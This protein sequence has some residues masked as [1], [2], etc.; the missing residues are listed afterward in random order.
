MARSTVPTYRA[1]VSRVKKDL[2]GERFGRLTVVSRGPDQVSAGGK[3]RACWNCVCD[4]GKH[5]L[6]A[7]FCLKSGNTKSCG[8]IK[9]EILQGRCGENHPLYLH[10]KATSPEY[11][12]WNGAV[13]RCQNES[14]ESYRNYGGRG[15]SV[16][17]RWANSFAAFL[18]DM[19]NRPPGT[20]LDRIDVNGNYEPGNCRWA[21]AKTQSRNQR[22]TIYIE[23]DGE[24]RSLPEWAEISGIPEP[25]IRSRY[26]KLGWPGK[27]AVFHPAVPYGQ[28]R[29]GE[30]T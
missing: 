7:G 19:G 5:C 10:G 8:C 4:C 2:T 6:T 29:K 30:G 20:S 22:K 25:T 3:I 13:L 28:K 26:G 23:I 17:D 18:E 14:Y 21:S 9:M 1:P 24:K 27:E 15:I 12:S 16:C 11:H